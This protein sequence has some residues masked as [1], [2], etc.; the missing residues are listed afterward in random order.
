MSG[1]EHLER[2]ATH[3]LEIGATDAVQRHV[4]RKVVEPKPVS[5]RKLDFEHRRPR[6]LREMMAEAT[7]VFFYVYPG[8]AS[9]AA[10]FLNGTE[11]QFGSLFQIG[12]AYAIGIAFA[13]ITCASTSGGHFNP[14]ITLCFAYWQGFPW[15]KVPY[16]IFAQV[17]GAFVAG[18]VLMGQYHE[19]ISVFTAESIA[20]GKGTVYNGG[21]ASILCTFPGETQNNLGYLFLIEW[22]VDSFIGIVIW[23]SLD[24]ANPFVSPYSAPFVIGLAYANMVWG[25]ADI[26]ISTNLARD[27]GTRIVAAIWFGGEAFS[28]KNYSWIAILVNV[29]ATFFATAYYEFL[30]RD[31]L[32]K[33]GHGHAVHEEG[34]EGLARHLT[35]TGKMEMENGTTSTLRKGESHV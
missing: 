12:W 7:G 28:Y 14:A 8:I 35:K 27:L 30:M 11:P 31:S 32:K 10:F 9:T 23:A 13:I 24:P 26:S 25:F 17:F 15:K 2:L 33:I 5:Q 4:T 18:L 22:F 20:A 19:Q 6:W 16:Y 34:E 29:P 3:E 1:N 21:P